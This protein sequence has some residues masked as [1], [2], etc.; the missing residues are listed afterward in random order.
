MGTRCVCWCVGGAM[1]AAATTSRL[2]IVF[3]ES[4]CDNCQSVRLAPPGSPGSPMNR[5]FEE[6]SSFTYPPSTTPP[7]L[8][9][10][11]ARCAVFTLFTHV[12]RRS[13]P[14][15]SF[16]IYQAHTLTPQRS[17]YDS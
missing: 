4:P 5:D 9:N 17:V 15:C 10:W 7:P 16:A 13:S 3:S 2:R 11:S 8:T 6:C 14:V 12:I 1:V